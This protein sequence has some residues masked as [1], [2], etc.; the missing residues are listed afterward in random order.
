[1][2]KKIQMLRINTERAEKLREKAID[3]TIK[4]KEIVKESE[5]INYLID[6]FTNRIDIDK[7]GFF[8]AEDN[9]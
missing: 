8:V 2:A 4:S 6:E 1:M 3:L 5:I 7:D 9:E